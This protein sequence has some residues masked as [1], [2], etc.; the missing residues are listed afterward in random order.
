[1][2]AWVGQRGGA[3]LCRAV[4]LWL[5]VAQV[6]PGC[7]GA[8]WGVGKMAVRVGVGLQA[9][10]REVDEHSPKVLISKEAATRLLSMGAEAVER[11]VQPWNVQGVSHQDHLAV[12]RDDRGAAPKDGRV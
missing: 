4:L 8:Q 2:V 6:V 7:T 10:V 12:Q 5:E 9:E 1:M 11:G 3:C